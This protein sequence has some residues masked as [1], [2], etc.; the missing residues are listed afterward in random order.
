V[1][2][3]IIQ[4]EK[5]GCETAFSKFDDF[6]SQ[7]RYA[8]LLLAAGLGSVFALW[9]PGRIVEVWPGHDI[10][11]GAKGFVSFCPT[12]EKVSDLLE[13]HP[14]I[15]ASTMMHAF[16]M[17][18]S[19]FVSVWNFIRNN[20]D[21]YR[22][23]CV[24]IFYEYYHRAM[25]FLLATSKAG[26]IPSNEASDAID[27]SVT[28][29]WSRDVLS[30]KSAKRVTGDILS[31]ALQH[32]VI[33]ETKR[34]VSE[35]HG[36]SDIFD[37]MECVTEMHQ[38]QYE[39][40]VYHQSENVYFSINVSNDRDSPFFIFGHVT[41]DEVFDSFQPNGVEIFESRV[42]NFEF[43]NGQPM[44][45][46]R[47]ADWV[48]LQCRASSGESKSREETCS[49]HLVRSRYMLHSM[50]GILNGYKCRIEVYEEAYGNI[51]YL[52]YGLPC[53]THIMRFHKNDYKMMS[54]N[55]DPEE[56][57]TAFDSVDVH[58]TAVLMGDRIRVTP[59]ANMHAFLKEV[60][61]FPGQRNLLEHK[62][63]FYRGRG[64]GRKL[65]SK[66]IKFENHEFL[67]TICEIH[68]ESDSYSLRILV[69]TQKTSRT[70]EYRLSPLERV[71]LFFGRSE[72]LLDDIIS[73]FKVVRVL[74]KDLD[75]DRN[76]L[77]PL[78]DDTCWKAQ[79]KH[80]SLYTRSNVD[81]QDDDNDLNGRLLKLY[82]IPE[83]TFRVVS[84]ILP[85][86]EEVF[87]RVAEDHDPAP[88]TDQEVRYAL[89]FDRA[90]ASRTIGNVKISVALILS[91]E[92]FLFTIYDKFRRFMNYAFVPFADIH[93][94]LGLPLGSLMRTIDRID[95]SDV[96]T[97][98][99]DDILKSV[100]LA[101]TPNMP[102]LSRL[103]VS[104]TDRQEIVRLCYA[105]ISEVE[106]HMSASSKDSQDRPVSAD[107]H[108]A[109]LHQSPWMQN[110]ERPLSA[111]S[112]T[113][114]P[115]INTMTSELVEEPRLKLG[116]QNMERPLSASSQASRPRINTMTS[117]LVEE[118]RLK[119]GVQNME[120]PL[121]ASSQASR[122]RINTMTSE[123]VEEPRLKLEKY[124]ESVGRK[125][126]YRFVR[127][128]SPAANL[129]NCSESDDVGEGAS[130]IRE[131][132]DP[133]ELKTTAT[134]SIKAPVENKTS[135]RK[136]VV[137]VYQ[138]KLNAL[139]ANTA[140]V[141]KVEIKKIVVQP[142]FVYEHVV[143]SEAE[144][145]SRICWR[146]K[147]YLKDV[148][149]VDKVVLK[150]PMQRALK[151]TNW[152]HIN[153]VKVI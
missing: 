117:E 6:E 147:L 124:V 47:M 1:G 126:N 42:P 62:I 113:S 118:P 88:I 110:M 145:P 8:F 131:Y 108:P 64:P 127:Y 50:I 125:K 52:I 150:R 37:V 19:S 31:A 98:L 16:I 49:L 17:G 138:S 75:D 7:Q 106:R 114:R 10:L 2:G 45:F 44:W 77:I 83:R 81:P 121:S 53:G 120:R 111:S 68:N 134:N 96:V 51:I 82:Y 137:N 56:E 140:K 139:N 142:S 27:V 72:L 85:T 24:R 115:R 109:S 135:K 105:E 36:R 101:T 33:F 61:L 146:G 136:S 41:Q 34:K 119:L 67:I 100:R 143:V 102:H 84:E 13:N 29:D 129:L 48:Q 30:D 9:K 11:L 86:G 32:A 141:E 5:E 95:D 46:E 63:F 4:V 116:V 90:G 74:K 71:L 104:S 57:R 26:G 40:S 92:G 76:G 87:N 93:K 38:N 148:E 39:M 28:L 123:L 43:G 153:N 14:L 60:A 91:R 59:S 35:Y 107:S 12:A 20:Y 73:R 97:E 151:L 152:V 99:F 149:S 112:Q 89:H 78:A 79:L 80:E 55:G 94:P 132:F 15:A 18:S 25:E 54:D 128:S 66:F 3:Y 21:H 130:Y 23:P 70:I 133:E 65:G 22:N 122:P 58:R 103:V 69:Y 144:D